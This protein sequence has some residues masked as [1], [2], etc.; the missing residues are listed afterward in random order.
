MYCFHVSFSLTPLLCQKIISD[1]FAS[2]AAR[3]TSIARFGSR[4]ECTHR[5]SH[6]DLH[7]MHPR[8][9]RPQAHKSPSQN[10][11]PIFCCWMA[12]SWFSNLQMTWNFLSILS[13]SSPW[14]SSK[15]VTPRNALRLQ[16]YYFIFTIF[17]TEWW[18]PI[19]ARQCTWSSVGPPLGRDKIEHGWHTVLCINHSAEIHSAEISDLN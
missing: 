19:A 1:S 18:W 17:T 11:N 13:I 12:V 10:L 5:A 8:S 9:M 3:W 16:R 6:A 7:A 2:I 15:C 14:T 4:D